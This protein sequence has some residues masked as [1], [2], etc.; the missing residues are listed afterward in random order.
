MDKKWVGIG[1]LVSAGMLAAALRKTLTIRS[2]ALHSQRLAAPIRLAVLT[3]LHST[4]MVIST[5][6]WYGH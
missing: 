4:F 1:G 2:Y 3:D 6:I 5:N